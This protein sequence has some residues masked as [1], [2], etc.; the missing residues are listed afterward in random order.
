MRIREEVRERGG[1]VVVLCGGSGAERTV[2]LASG[3]A[4][5][6]ALLGA[7]LPVTCFELEAD[8]LPEG[9]D[10]RRDIVLP[11]VHGTYGEDG[12]LS[13]DLER[14]G[15]A[16]GGSDA[17]SSALAFDKARCKEA[18]GRLGLPVARHVS[19]AEGED[20][21]PEAI[22]ERVGLPFVLKPCCEGSSVG[23]MILK[24]VE[25]SR[26]RLPRQAQ[27]AL[28]AEAF[29]PGVDATVAVFGDAV[30]GTV[31]IHPSGGVYDYAHKYTSGWTRYASPAELDRAVCEV[32]EADALAIFRACGCRDLGRVDFRVAEDGRHVFLE[33]NTLPGMTSTSLFPMA[34]KAAGLTF[35]EVLLR[36]VGMAMSRKEGLA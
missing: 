18:A 33:L 34:A 20:L 8:A 36:W 23:L 14:V 25:E 5:A 22:V 30:L 7:G 31:S 16:Y 13:A 24:S 21:C 4:V 28:M 10:P 2:S 11:L 19:L 12:R 3:R 1:R 35:E 9:L 26:E 6:E 15:F 27:R 17:G 32:M 29:C